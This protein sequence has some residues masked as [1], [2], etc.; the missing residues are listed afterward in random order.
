[1]LPENT[2]KLPIKFPND[3]QSFITL[4]NYM[5]FLNKTEERRESEK[6][7][8]DFIDKQIIDSLVYELYFK[9]KFEQDGIKTNLLQL[10]EPYLKDIE[11]LKSDEEKL[12]TIK[13]VTE[14]IRNDSKVMKEI[15]KIKSHKWVK[16][17]EG[18]KNDSQS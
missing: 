13:Q 17:I 6:D 1:V 3:Q 10:V 14:K 16:I 15:E 2:K 4:C 7:I 12:K 8:I 9:E 5:L 11:N 18:G